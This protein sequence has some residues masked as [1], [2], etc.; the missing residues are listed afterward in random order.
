M[1]PSAISEVLGPNTALV[2][3]RV[4]ENMTNPEPKFLDSSGQFPS[5]DWVEWHMRKYNVGRSVAVDHA[6]ARMD[7]HHRLIGADEA[8]RILGVRRMKLPQQ[9]VFRSPIF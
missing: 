6:Y 4:K 1:K 8:L 7:G 5:N 2:L 3:Q 9:Q